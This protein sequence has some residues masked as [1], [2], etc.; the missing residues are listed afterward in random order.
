MNGVHDQ[1]GMHGFGPIDPEPEATE[2]AFHAEWEKR[3][4]ALNLACGA[5]GR[6]NI[7]ASR[8]SR[9]RLD[10]VDYLSASYYAKWI[11]GLE[12]LLVETGIVTEEELWTGQPAGP[13]PQELTRRRLSAD[14]VEPALAAV[15]PYDMDPPSPPRFQAG[16]RVRV[17]H[18]NTPGHTRAVR[19]ARGHVGTVRTHHGCH[20]F[21]DANAHGDRR[22]EHLYG[23]AFD[24]ADMW[25]DTRSDTVHIDLW[26]PYLEAIA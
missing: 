4:L 26:E 15:R 21:P 9:E 23:V 10:P 22:G 8:H 2:P 1:G 14:R 11:K 16:E 24:A 7:D 19:Y 20:V 18:V 25:G 5:L 12:L 6:W 17:R 13:A 3:A